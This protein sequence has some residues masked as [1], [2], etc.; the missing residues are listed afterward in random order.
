MITLGAIGVFG[1]ERRL[2]QD[3]QA[4]EE[5]ECLITVEITEV[6]TSLLVQQLQGEQVQQRAGGGHHM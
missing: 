4:G 5:T 1:G 6:T 3:V 2:G